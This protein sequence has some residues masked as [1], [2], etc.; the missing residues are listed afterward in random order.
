[1]VCSTVLRVLTGPIYDILFLQR[2]FTAILLGR[3]SLTNLDNNLEV[4]NQIQISPLVRIQQIQY[5]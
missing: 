5:R 4:Q 3:K 1:M 2:K